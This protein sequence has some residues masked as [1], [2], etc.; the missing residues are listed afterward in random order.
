MSDSHASSDGPIR[1]TGSVPGRTG[2]LSFIPAA[3]P[4]GIPVLLM[5]EPRARRR[6]A[7]QKTDS[8][9][10]SAGGGRDDF[11]SVFHTS[12]VALFDVL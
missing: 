6:G 5:L 10:L 1:L 8:R 2:D 7:E 4:I 9:D 12:E 3:A 11:G